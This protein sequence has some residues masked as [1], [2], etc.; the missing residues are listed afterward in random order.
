MRLYFITGG[1]DEDKYSF[2]EP[3]QIKKLMIRKQ[4]FTD[5]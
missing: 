3:G 4:E 2:D 5:L 1:D